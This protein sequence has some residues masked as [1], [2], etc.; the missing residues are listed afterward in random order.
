[1]SPRWL[2]IIKSSNIEEHKKGVNVKTLEKFTEMTNKVGLVNH[3][4]FII[5][6]PRE[7]VETIKATVEWAKTLKVDSYQFTVPKPYPE[8]PFYEWLEE[9]GFLNDGRVNYPY[10]STEGIDKWVKWALRET[11]M[12]PRYL[13]RM[14]KKPRE[15]KRLIRSARYVV[16]NVVRG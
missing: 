14:M 7:T 9:N 3:A 1:M 15:W 10:L 16:P 13:L 2:R 5:G 11:N 8:T 6:L 12:N 4:D